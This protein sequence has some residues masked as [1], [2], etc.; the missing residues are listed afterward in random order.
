[1]QMD[2]GLDTGDMLLVESLPIASNDTT[3]SLHDKLASMG[4][5]LIVEALEI[6][7]CGGLPATAQPQNGISYAHKI[8]KAEAQI[9]WALSAEQIHNKVRAFNPAPGANTL[10]RGELL[11]VWRSEFNSTPAP[12]HAG[13]GHICSINASGIHVATGAGTLCV[14]ELQRA[15]GK[16]M[17]A[18]DCARGLGLQVGEKLGERQG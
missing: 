11:K 17:S 8:E 18:T 14:T 6:A 9:D 13:T 3:A 7:A 10:L 5:R 12:F 4:G 16:R 2:A 15:G 1:M